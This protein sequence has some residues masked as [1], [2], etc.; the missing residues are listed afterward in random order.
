MR[1]G[2][3]HPVLDNGTL[4]CR[5]NNAL[6]RPVADKAELHVL[7]RQFRKFSSPLH[8]IFQTI[9]RNEEAVLSPSAFNI[10]TNALL[11]LKIFGSSFAKFLFIRSRFL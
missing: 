1:L 3:L 4:E 5:G 2:P 10:Y 7:S 9:S 8:Y 11:S 6:D